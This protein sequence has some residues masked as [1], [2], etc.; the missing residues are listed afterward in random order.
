MFVS[1]EFLQ[2][3]QRNNQ[4]VHSFQGSCTDLPHDNVVISLDSCSPLPELTC[5]FCS[6]LWD[7]F[8]LLDLESN[9]KLNLCIYCTKISYWA[10]WWEQCKDVIVLFVV[11]SYLFPP[12]LFKQTFSF[13]RFYEKNELVRSFSA[14]GSVDLRRFYNKYF[15]SAFKE[16]EKNNGFLKYKGLV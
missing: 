13:G 1:I 14:V 9:C 5:Y 2:G 6:S 15:G 16:D 10:W 11:P 7:L 12:W 8:I 4:T 3:S